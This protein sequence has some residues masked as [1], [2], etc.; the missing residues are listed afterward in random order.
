M[1]WLMLTLAGGLASF[2][3]IAPGNLRHSEREPSRSALLGLCAAA[4]GLR[5]DAVDAQRELASVLRF[6]SRCAAS[7]RLLRDYHTTQA[8]PQPALKGRPRQTRRDELSVPKDD[9]NTVL[10][11]REYYCDYVATVGIHCING[12]RLQEL[13]I[14]L[15][16]PKFTLYLGRKSCPLAWPMDPLLIS[17][18]RWSEALSRY[19]EYFGRRHEALQD[20]STKSQ[21]R[22]LSD[23]QRSWWSKADQLHSLDETLA[24]VSLPEQRRVTRW[25]EPMD[26]G[27]RQFAPRLQ[28]RCLERRS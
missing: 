26:T 17:A 1:Q 28:L 7:A 11:E 18:E 22:L 2:G 25:D 5:R 4:L 14:A 19:D 16:K 9:L 24:D 27:K 15:R 8:P 23:V 12:E 10:S 13:E 3:G 6:A 20:S 21:R